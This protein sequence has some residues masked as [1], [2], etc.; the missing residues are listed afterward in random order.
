MVAFATV[1]EAAGS[2]VAFVDPV[3]VRNDEF[4]EHL[5]AD[6]LRRVVSQ[7]G[8]MDPGPSREVVHV[9]HAMHMALRHPIHESVHPLRVLGHPEEEVRAGQSEGHDDLGRPIGV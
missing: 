3:A 1:V 8:R 7:A 4:L 5:Q 9:G 2:G 6:H